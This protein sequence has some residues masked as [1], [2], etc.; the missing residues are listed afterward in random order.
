MEESEK[1]GRAFRFLKRNFGWSVL[2]QNSQI[3]VD[4]PLR[5][6]HSL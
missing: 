6:G 4:Q 5:L 2:K 1:E 3:E